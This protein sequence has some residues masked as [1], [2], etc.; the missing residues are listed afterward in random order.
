MHIFIVCFIVTSVP[1]SNVVSVLKSLCSVVSAH[2]TPTFSLK[3]Y[4]LRRINVKK[5]ARYCI[6]MMYLRYTIEVCMLVCVNALIFHH[7]KQNIPGVKTSKH[8]SALSTFQQSGVT[9]FAAVL[10]ISC[11]SMR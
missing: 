4:L 1:Q 5:V 7:Y 9:L 8:Y 3:L 11:M 10:S 2:F 6:G